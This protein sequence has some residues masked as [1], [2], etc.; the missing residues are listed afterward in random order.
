MGN[1]SSAGEASARPNTASV[2]SP[3]FK[4]H[5]SAAKIKAKS[6]DNLL[7]ATESDSTATFL[8]QTTFGKL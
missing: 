4:Q 1:S 3:R 8:T 5:S 2:A 6:K 7:N